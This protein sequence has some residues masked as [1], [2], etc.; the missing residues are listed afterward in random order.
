MPFA[1]EDGGSLGK[2]A[3]GLF[4]LLQSICANQVRFLDESLQTWSAKGFA[5]FYLQLLS[6]AL[7]RGQGHLFMQ[8]AA[9]IRAAP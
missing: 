9:A 2:E 6:V 7:L 5:N 1:I 4:K 3:L 8:A